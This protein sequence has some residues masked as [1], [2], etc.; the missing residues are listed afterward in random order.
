MAASRTD[1]DSF[2]AKVKS[3]RSELQSYGADILR[4]IT[5]LYGSM[6]PSA[7]PIN[8]K[9]VPGNAL[10]IL[11][12]DVIELLQETEVAQ[13][14]RDKKDLHECEGLLAVLK[15]VSAVG[16]ALQRCDEATA[17]GGNNATLSEACK[18]LNA[19]MVLL[20]TL[21]ADN[22]ELGT[23][24]VVT[25]LRR[26]A[27]LIKSRFASRLQRLLSQCLVFSAGSLTVTKCLRGIVEGEEGIVG[28]GAGSGSLKGGIALEEVW[29]AMVCV[30]RAEACLAGI[31][32]DVWGFLLRPLW[33]EKKGSAA[34]RVC[35]SGD[36]AE[37]LLG[38]RPAL[39]AFFYHH[40]HAPSLMFSRTNVPRYLLYFIYPLQ[41]PLFA[42]THP[43]A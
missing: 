21:P 14:S 2:E 23:G 24:A 9:N 1:F 25:L 17:G 29:D 8:L 38:A 39:T 12:H 6:P 7:S 33:R 37:L 41:R 35:T 28:M 31:V 15:H 16:E 10:K 30:G 20:Q 34:P 32:R 27:A 36:R 5:A 26:E 42:T 40:P 11:Q 43:P 4:Q 13:S 22:T 3:L 19:L 18:E